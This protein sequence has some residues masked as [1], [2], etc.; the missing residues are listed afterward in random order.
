V[1]ARKSKIFAIVPASS[2]VSVDVV[3]RDLIVEMSKLGNTGLVDIECARKDL[4]IDARNIT[5]EHSHNALLS[6]WLAGQQ[7]CNDFILLIAEPSADPWSERCAKQADMVLLVADATAD[8]QPGKVEVGLFQAVAKTGPV[9]TALL[10]LHPPGTV[11]PTGTALWLADRQLDAHYH[12]CRDRQGDVARLARL[13]T[14]NAVGVVLGGGGARG[15]AH[16]GV[17]RA[18][19]ESGIPIDVIG[20]TSSG[21]GIAAQYAMGMDDETILQTNIDGFVNN[22]PFK[23]LTLP[24]ISIIGRNKMDALAKK[25]CGDLQIEDLWINFFCVSCNLTKGVI[26]NHRQGPL[27]KAVRATSSLPGIAVPVIQDGEV[28]VDGG[29]MDNLPGLVMRQSMGGKVV[30]VDVSPDQ[31]MQVDIEYENVP[32]GWQVLW[33]QLWPFGKSIRF[34]KISEVLQRTVTVSSLSTRTQTLEDA[35][36]VLHPPVE[37]YGMMDFSAVEDIAANAYEYAMERLQEADL[38]R[39]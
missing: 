23:R 17:L 5:A 6:A 3:A 39:I 20:G 36:L 12:L 14:G 1:E 30:V 38:P 13:L 2:K 21:G 33:N 22:N 25:M 19:R 37:E 18:L 27:W 29:V 28:L 4:G 8:P 11:A 9:P 10:L 35:D 15:G 26:E 24:V 7:E 32:S 31:G 16:I 34:P